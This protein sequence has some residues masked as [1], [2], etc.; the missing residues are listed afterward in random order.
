[1]SMCVN[2]MHAHRIPVHCMGVG[3]R[4][5]YKPWIWGTPNLT[6]HIVGAPSGENI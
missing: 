1:M 3:D 4:N 6:E 2:D 5:D